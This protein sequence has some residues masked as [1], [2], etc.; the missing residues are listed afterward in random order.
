M[1]ENRDLFLI[2]GCALAALV[3][4]GDPRFVDEQSAEPS[5]RD[6]LIQA[7]ED[8]YVEEARSVYDTDILTLSQ[9]GDYMA[10]KI[11]Q[12][13]LDDIS[14]INEEQTG[15]PIEYDRATYLQ[16]CVQNLNVKRS[17]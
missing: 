3:I 17:I 13:S 8:E 5:Q 7:M 12:A 6:K 1:S 4:L 14:D 16:N 11:S 9:I 10:C 15:E 2:T